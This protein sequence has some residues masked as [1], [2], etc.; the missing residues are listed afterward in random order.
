M[1]PLHSSAHVSLEG[2]GF[3]NILSNEVAEA[4]GPNEIGDKCEAYDDL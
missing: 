1:K 2:L 4:D 3:L